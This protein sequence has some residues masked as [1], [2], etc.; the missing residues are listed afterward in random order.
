VRTQGFQT[1][2]PICRLAA[3]AL[4]LAMLVVAPS[5]AHATGE[6]LKRATSNILMAP[7]DIA[8]SPIVA[9]K[10]IVTNMREIDDTVPVRVAYALPGY[11]FLTGVQAGAGTIRAIS[12]VLEFLPGLGLLFFDNDLDPLYD[13]VERGDALVDYDTRFLNL[14][15][16]IDYTG[17]SA[18]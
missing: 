5:P 16:G 15:F 18:Y 9:A 7:F 11:V 4:A 14:K 6:T 8:L 12:G 3:G 10:T 17:A 1:V 13:P 2:G